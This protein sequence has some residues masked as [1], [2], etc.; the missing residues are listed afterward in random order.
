VSK[1]A[2]P[3]Q[4]VNLKIQAVKNVGSS[5]LALAVTVAVGF[6]LAPFILHKLGDEA[7]GLWILVF[8]LTGYYGLFDLGIRSTIVRYVSKLT[9]TGDDDQLSRIINTSFLS[10]SVLA[11]SLLVVTAIGSRVIDLLFHVPPAFLNTAP[12]LFLIVGSSIALNFPL[13]LFAGILEGLQKFYWLNLIQIISIL[14]RAWLI[15]V[16]LNRGGGLVTLTLITVSFPLLSSVAHILMVR[17]SLPL[18]FG[19]KFVDRRSFR[20]LISYGAATFMIIVA[21]RLRF[22]TDALVIGMFLSSSAITLFSIGSK[23]VDYPTD[24]VQSLAQIFTPMSSQFD[25]TGDTEGLR[26]MFVAGNRACA[27][28][29]FPICAALVI[30]GRSLIEIWV[31]PKYLASYA[32]LL[33]LVLSTTLY[34]AQATST[35][36][37]FGIS[38]HRVLAAVVLVEGAANL[39]LSIVLVRYL[40]IIGVALG[41]AIPLTCTS[42]FFLPLHLCRIL[43]IPLGTFLRQA[44]LLPLA[45][46][47]PF[48]VALLSM[49]HLFHARTYFQFMLQL[50]PGALVYG[51]GLLW[52]FFT[53]EAMGIKMWT[54]FTQFLHESAGWRNR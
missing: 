2:P 16:A 8:S 22:Q 6:F 5:W 36:I 23:L 21:A 54:R 24:V 14:L 40:G 46:C 43:K 38:R 45:L 26:K 53:R 20:Q 32:I 49:R 3:H 33:I 9:T 15:V 37:L 50:G 27:L 44:Y 11:V 17:R 42:I 29:I 12:L 48:A 34:S 25:S 13:G 51:V 31:G 7:Y 28:T 1:G 35:K 52:L 30:L 47:A 39:V 41:T 19:A 4:P 10:Y 18:P